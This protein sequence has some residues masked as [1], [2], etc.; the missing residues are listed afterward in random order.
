MN[1]L[2]YSLEA[3]NIINKFHNVD[4]L[5]YVEGEDD[6]RFWEIIFEKTATFSVAIQPTD[7]KQELNKRLDEVLNHGAQ[8]LI[9]KDA[10]YDLLDECIEHTQVIYS[11]GYSIENT[12][13][14]S[15]TIVKV[16]QNVGRLSKN[17]VPNEFAQ[18][19]L[20]TFSTKA[21]KLLTADIISKQDNLGISVMAKNYNRFTSE[22]IP[23][24]L[25][26][27]KIDNFLNSNV[28]SVDAKRYQECEGLLLSQTRTCLDLV[29]GHFLFS[30][31]ARFIKHE[32]VSRG[33]NCS[34]SNRAL[35]GN[36]LSAFELIFC[37]SHSHFDYYRQKI[38][39]I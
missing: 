1:E 25:C 35:F 17:N 16:I 37:K 23:Y 22:P 4:K 33:T 15:G 24:E 34:L 39:A 27:K 3:R 29:V 7:G 6:I 19:W 13:I 8:Y 5:I 38:T 12:F 21:F 14:S 20:D 30:A 10:D 11:Y 9:A 18:I 2:S 28:G 32:L 36:L 31:T 26:E